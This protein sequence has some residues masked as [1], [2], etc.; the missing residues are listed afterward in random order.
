[1]KTGIYTTK[2]GEYIYLYDRE[3]NLLVFL[4]DKNETPGRT[5]FTPEDFPK[6][7]QD[8]LVFVAGHIMDFVQKISPYVTPSTNDV[9]LKRIVEN[10]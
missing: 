3:E 8:E 4:G 6:G 10:A 5:D 2:N 9:L 7:A 1:M